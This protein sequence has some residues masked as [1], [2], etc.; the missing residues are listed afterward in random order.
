MDRGR[1]G[2]WKIADL[3]LGRCE[4]LRFPLS[5]A[6]PAQ[7]PLS[8]PPTISV[9]LAEPPSDVGTEGGQ[10]VLDEWLAAAAV[11]AAACDEVLAVSPESCN[12]TCEVFDDDALKP[13]LLL[14]PAPPLP[15]DPVADPLDAP[16]DPVENDE[17]VGKDDVGTL[18]GSEAV[19]VLPVWSL[20]V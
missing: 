2:H 8:E 11:E 5:N 20:A 13:A 1:H 14:L 18:S 4:E 19:P 3:K 6:M 16:A 10:I 17:P 7:H 15:V 9:R 12:G